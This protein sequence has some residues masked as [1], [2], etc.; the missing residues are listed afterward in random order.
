MMD[1]S[2]G[3]RP[4]S[5][6][7]KSGKSGTSGLKSCLIGC[8]IAPFVLILFAL[9]AIMGRS[10]TITD[11]REFYEEAKAA[12][13]EP[14]PLEDDRLGDR[15]PEFD[16]E[17]V[18]RRP[19]LR[20]YSG[21]MVVN[22]SAAVI[23]LDVI[24]ADPKVEP[25]LMKLHAN[26]SDAAAFV[27]AGG[28]EVIPSINSLDGKAKQF[29]DGFYA[30]LDAAFTHGKM[31]AFHDTSGLVVDIMAKLDTGGEAYAWLWGALEV[32]GFLPEGPATP[33]P[34]GAAVFVAE[35]DGDPKASKPIGFY[36]WSD[37]LRRTFRFLRY[38]QWKWHTR[39]GVPDGIAAVLAADAGLMKRYE[40]MIDFYAHLTNPMSSPS[41][42]HLIGPTSA[43]LNVRAI[44]LAHGFE[45]KGDGPRVQ[46]LPYSGSKE[47]RLFTRLFGGRTLPPGADLMM[48]FVKAIRSGAVDLAPGED[49]GWY[50]Y[51]IYA[52]ET[53]L[54][55][56]R[57]KEKDKLLLTRTYKE[58]LLEAFKT[59]L[60]KRRETHVRQVD[61]SIGCSGGPPEEPEPITPRIRIEPAPTYF[62]RMARSYA[63]I[64]D[65][66]AATVPEEVM[67]ALVGRTRDGTRGK[68]LG[69]ELDWM[70]RFFYGLHLIACDDIGM[71]PDLLEDELSDPDACEGLALEW[72]R[73][74][75][76]DPDMAVD[77]R[78]VVP[79]FIDPS[80][81]V[82][83]FWGT[84]GVRGAKLR[85]TYARP[86][87]WASTY[88]PAGSKPNW[89][90]VPPDRLAPQEAVI[91]VDEFVEFERAG[92]V[93]LT[94]D[95]FR[96]ICDGKGTKE[97]ILEALSE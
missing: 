1:I 20:E 73:D 80:R 74:W 70:R 21:S 86:P 52:L 45:P 41:F 14:G 11:V 57:G 5:E 25:Y 13:R 59:I 93:P 29:D 22:A 54:L 3:G 9:M 49:S 91:L 81:G 35:F 38:L 10:G 28:K 56:G 60:T 24:G 31:K 64:R 27:E 30:E 2:A 90:T 37:E 68:P 47:S 71:G 23:E 76:S 87:S 67:G 12:V 7:G 77:T 19:F 18:M 8:V 79:I 63:F 43:L 94:R 40:T 26:Y 82:T 92:L 84:A 55:P 44:E 88:V 48:E 61:V 33:A 65:Y 50:D 4:S 96:E 69:E 34:A 36:T 66:L 58:R 15:A 72:L 46:F 39:R 83:R 6:A 75:R 17:L 85:A 51:Q 42:K 97:E 32:G 62:L 78:V 53:F 89:R 16:P 95:E